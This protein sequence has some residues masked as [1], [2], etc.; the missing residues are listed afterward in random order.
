MNVEEITRKFSYKF[1]DAY[2]VF[3]I[4]AVSRPDALKTFQEH[5]EVIRLDDNIDGP[6]FCGKF[7]DKYYILST[8]IVNATTNTITISEAK[9]IPMKFINTLPSKDF[10]TIVD[11]FYKKISTD[12]S[13]FTRTVSVKTI[14]DPNSKQEIMK[15]GMITSVDHGKYKN[16]QEEYK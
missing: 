1:G 15:I 8:G 12:P 6:I 9:K 14:T 3:N 11:S 2:D 5:D 13:Q 16:L 4:V 10:V 7:F